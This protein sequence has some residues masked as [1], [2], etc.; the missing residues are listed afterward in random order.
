[1]AAMRASPLSPIRPGFV[2]LATRTL[3]HDRVRLALSIG[4]IAFA[5][6]LVVI[7]RAIMDGTVRRSTTYLD[8]V[9]ADVVVAQAGVKNMMLAAS[10]LPEAVVGSV[11]EAEGVDQAAGI[12]R[13]AVIVT[14]GER[15]LPVNA[16][17][18][19]EEGLGGP[20]KLKSGRLVQAPDE[21][22]VDSD[23]AEKLGVGIGDTVTIGDRG[24]RVVGISRET[25]AIAGKLMFVQRATLQ[26][27]MRLPGRVNFVL[28]TLRPGFDPQAVADAINGGSPG[29]TAITVSE[30]SR[31]D[32]HLL[33]DLFISPIQVATTTGFLVGLA[34]V[35]LTMYT[36]TS[37][38]LRDFGVLKAIGAPNS[39]LLQTVIGQA[40]ALAVVGYGL[41]LC[42]TAL[43]GP[44]IT[45]IVPDIGVIITL[46]N[47]LRALGA[48][49]AMS[50]FGAL[51]PVAR[52]MRVDPLM[53]FRRA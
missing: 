38:R 44:I 18:Y 23:L 27:L 40:L 33:S 48:V 3:L 24:Y 19:G 2:H 37:E 5:I 34:I 45:G 9:G 30:L 15:T 14:N 28:V 16:V 51:V 20:W 6:V 39:Y 50:L 8:H 25:T 13:L 29:A 43:A 46:A 36:T 10:I 17:G 11:G 22:V 35:G 1:M 4:G 52:I 7:L 12:M 42:L 47:A 21:C 49:V 32:R 31:N 41:G 53:V 26:E